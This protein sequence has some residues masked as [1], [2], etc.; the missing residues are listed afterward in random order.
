MK[1][2][3]GSGTAEPELGSRVPIWLEDEPWRIGNGVSQTPVPS[4]T[5]LKIS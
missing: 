3:I 5:D 2:A 4:S 1:R